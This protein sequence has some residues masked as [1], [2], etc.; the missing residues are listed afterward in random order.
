MKELKRVAD[1][2]L[3]IDSISHHPDNS[4][5][6]QYSLTLTSAISAKLLKTG[7]KG[8][9]IFVNKFAIFRQIGE[10]KYKVKIWKSKDNN[11]MIG[12]TTAKGFGVMSNYV[13]SEAV[14]YYIYSNNGS[15]YE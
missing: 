8:W 7:S 13:S 11:L 2:L 5:K 10:I 9:H 12:F 15:L 4:H 1:F 3:R 14:Y 6:N